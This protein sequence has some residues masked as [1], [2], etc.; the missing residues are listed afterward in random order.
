MP[1]MAVR[2]LQHR[3]DDLVVELVRTRAERDSERARADQ[4]V[5]LRATLAAVEAERDRW[6]QAATAPRGWVR[7][8]RRA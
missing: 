3:I 6:H 8:F 4:V 2:D 5:A 7:I 1:V